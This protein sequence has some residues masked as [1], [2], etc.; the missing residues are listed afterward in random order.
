MIVKIKEPSGDSQT[1]WAL[2]EL[3]GELI[4]P[5]DTEGRNELELGALRFTPDVS[6]Y[7]LICTNKSKPDFFFIFLTLYDWCLR[8]YQF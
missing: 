5:T 4:V 2:I 7:V 3:N 6:F 8:G 1:E